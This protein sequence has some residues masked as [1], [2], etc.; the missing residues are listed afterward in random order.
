MP[1]ILF[2]QFVIWPFILLHFLK[3]SNGGN[4]I[5]MECRFHWTHWKKWCHN[6]IIKYSIYSVGMRAQLLSHVRLC[7]PMYSSPPGSSVHRIFPARILGSG[8]PFLPPGES[9]K[10]RDQTH[11]SC[12]SCIAGEFFTTEPLGEPYLRYF[13]TYILHCYLNV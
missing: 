1:Q 11:L 5:V 4:R 7:D 6:F 3:V 9:S 10:S 12:I 13:R 2:S 8:L